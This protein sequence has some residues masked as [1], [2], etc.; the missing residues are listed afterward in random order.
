MAK[1][2]ALLT[3]GMLLAAPSAAADTLK[4]EKSK[5]RIHVDAKATGHEFT[6]TLKDYEVKVS[7]DP[8]DLAPQTFSLEWT[9]D[10]LETGDKERDEQMLKWLGG[11]KPAG[12][13]K[14]TK[15]WDDAEGH[16]HGMGTLT[17]HGVS[18]KVSFPY[19]VEKDGRWVTIDGTAEL[20]Y[21]DFKLPIIRAMAVMT[22]KPELHV[23]F[24]IVGKL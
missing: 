3:C 18:Q 10:H 14:F 15:H 20:N 13:F 24:H 19:T 8:S 6:A 7:G 23:R 2:L 22:V 17:F 21:E 16:H 5:S 11:G 9:F 1:S 4:V 12:S